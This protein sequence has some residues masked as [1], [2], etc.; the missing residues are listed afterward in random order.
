[1]VVAG[2][3]YKVLHTRYP[4]VPGRGVI[5]GLVGADY[6]E[7]DGATSKDELRQ[8][9]QR[10]FEQRDEQKLST[11]VYWRSVRQRERSGFFHSLRN[12]LNYRLK[13]VELVALDP[14]TSMEYMLEGTTFRPALPPI[15]RMVATYEGQGN[16]KYFSASYF[17]GTKDDR[18]YIDLTVRQEVR[19]R[20]TGS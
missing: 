13:K 8:L 20:V 15:G 14:N 9:F 4:W 19:V 10:Y 2:P 11:L 16:V 17:I 6:R 7:M 1:M 18:Y 3:Y 12:D 5:Q